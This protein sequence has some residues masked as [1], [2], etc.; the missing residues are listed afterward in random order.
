MV[1]GDF[2]SGNILVNKDA[3]T[4]TTTAAVSDFGAA[5]VLAPGQTSTK[6]RYVVALLAGQQHQQHMPQQ[7]A[8]RL[9]VC[10]RYP[11]TCVIDDQDAA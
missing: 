6:C 10:S 9:I 3:E 11:L 2:K 8:A 5:Q 1:H 4:G 7:S